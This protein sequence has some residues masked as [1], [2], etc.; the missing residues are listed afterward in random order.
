MEF[1]RQWLIQDS[2]VTKETPRKKATKGVPSRCCHQRN[3]T[4]NFVTVSNSMR[5][6]E[7]KSHLMML[8]LR[9]DLR[10]FNLAG[11]ANSDDKK[12]D[13]AAPQKVH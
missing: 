1:S 6:F 11:V 8:T 10:S 3:S 9:P 7:L 4:R 13:S 2:G 5:L 12:I